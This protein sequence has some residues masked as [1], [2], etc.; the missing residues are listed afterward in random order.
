MTQSRKRAGKDSAPPTPSPVPTT[1]PQMVISAA[2]VAAL[3]L[4][5]A[6][7][8]AQLADANLVYSQVNASPWVSRDSLVSWANKALA[9]GDGPV[10]RLNAAL[11]LL[12]QMG[13]AFQVG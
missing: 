8:V 5:P 4:D 3:G 1:P 7:A 11:A 12:R 2:Q 9:G 10:N 13:L 6:T